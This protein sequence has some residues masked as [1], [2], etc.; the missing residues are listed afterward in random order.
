MACRRALHAHCR[1][2]NICLQHLS[3][4]VRNS[5][6]NVKKFHTQS[7]LSNKCEF[8][9]LFDI[10][11][12]IVRGKKPLPL[13]KQAFQLL[14]KD[15]QFKVPTLFV[16]NAGNSLRSKKAQQLSEWLDIEVSEEQVVMSHSPLKMFRQFHDKHCLVNGQGPI[17]EIAQNIGFTHVTTTE[18]LNQQFPNLDKMD[19][20]RRKPAPCAFEEY[21][22][23]IDAVILFGEPVR[24]EMPLQIITDVLLTNGKPC[25]DLL[26]IPYPHLPV[27]ACNMDLLWMSEASM[28]R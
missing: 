7:A 25:N 9:F 28:P 24:W 23:R 1:Q 22:P 17:K 16:T 27:L 19:H 13:A 26:E 2:H 12:V 18:E 20:L 6:V 3:S 14:T 4:S 8:G 11:G 21:F 5:A 15:R 10:D